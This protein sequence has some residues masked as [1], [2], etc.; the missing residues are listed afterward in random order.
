ME[1]GGGGGGHTV[2]TE[3]RGSKKE[4]NI[5]YENVGGI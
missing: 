1:G 4:K 5:L 3:L 2:S